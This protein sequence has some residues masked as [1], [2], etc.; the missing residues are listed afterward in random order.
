MSREMERLSRD[1]RDRFIEFWRGKE[2]RILKSAPLVPREDP[3]LLFTSAGMV[4]F[5][6][7]YASRDPLEYRRA[8]TVQKCLRATDLE[9]VGYTPRHCTFFEMLGHF[10]FGDYFKREAIHW[11]WEFFTR[12]MGLPVEKLQVSVFEEDDEAFAI[13]R[14]EIGLPASVIHRLGAADNFWGPAGE[15]GACGPSSE[16]YYDLG[17]DLGPDQK[18]G[19]EGD[20]WIEVG[21]FVFPQFDRQEDGRDLPLPNRGID[22]GIGLER[23]T[24]VMAGKRTIFE[25]D[26]FA[27][28]IERVGSLGAAPYAADRRPAYH[29]IADHV[30]ALAFALTEGI[31][32]SNEGRGYVIRRILRRAAVQGHR[33]GLREPFLHRLAAT[34]VAEMG[35]VYPE[36]RKAEE[37]IRVT[38]QAEEERFEATLEQGLSRLDELAGK[39][40]SDG[41]LSGRSLFMLYDTFGFPP[42]LT[43][44]LARER[45][46]EVD[47]EGFEREMDGQRERSRASA[48]FHD[49]KDREL[50]WTRF[51]DC[52]QVRF[53]GY[54]KLEVEA[55]LCRIAPVPE[56]DGE[57]WVVAAETPFYA[58]AGGQVGDVG[59]IRGEGLAG[60]VL[61][62][63][64][65]DGE[66]RHRVRLEEGTWAPGP[67]RL[68]VDARARASTMR[69]HTATHLLHAALRRHL[70]PHVTQAGSLVAPDRLRFDF[71]HTGA[72][73]PEQIEQV[74]RTV[75]EQV[76]ADTAVAIR[77][78]T[79]DE[80]IAEGVTA[81]FGEK[82]GDTVRRIGVE[83]FSEELCGGTHVSRTGEIGTFTIL[84][85]AGIAAGVR[86]IEA[87]TGTGAVEARLEQRRL[88][89][90]IREQLRAAPEE[91]PDR[92]RKVLEE[93]QK[94]KKEVAALKT[95]GAAD[96]LADLWRAGRDL[97]NG[98]LLVSELLLEDTGGIR[99][100][101]DR[102]RARLG[103]GIGLI[104][105]RAGSKT[106]LLAVVTDD[107]IEA[108]TA[109]ADA[110]VREA[111][112]IAGGSGGGRPHLAMAGVK[113]A[114]RLEEILATM[115]DR[116]AGRLGG[117][118][119][120][121]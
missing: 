74:E 105:V 99:E 31:L 49:R 72:M 22:T 116:L 59:T 103:S 67:V 94:L 108:G 100:V 46:L 35:S 52:A 3:T 40:A 56:A 64:A 55:P 118:G 7:L 66:T 19:D 43:A 32:P 17:E 98:T 109:R 44:V 11:N 93:N 76:M 89:E 70:G 23:L 6:K 86:R 85:E 87:I 42:D 96:E 8:A 79:Y 92:I 68:I 54:E 115:R 97:P 37:P 25:T 50:E 45:G 121:G 81:L 33:L 51:R 65:A 77:H 36:L 78:S 114:G 111:A 61:D 63:R 16:L 13:W 57:W 48:T 18:P 90:A 26:L 47:L 88:V 41:R 120:E 20:R 112:E 113:E 38:L 101:G 5:K 119:G 84:S 82:Y 104:G 53:V 15:T 30:R 14:D 10:S 117:S 12:V 58:E 2:H 27:P 73:T 21:N 34:A 62:T 110:V 91:I 69:N 95:R 71:T 24:M 28:I 29:I 80:A 83:G 4:P 9:E 107:L 60:T 75:N 39:E 106:T 102:I 1:V